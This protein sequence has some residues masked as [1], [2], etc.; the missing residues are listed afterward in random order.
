MVDLDLFETDDAV[1]EELH[2]DGRA[3]ICYFSAGSLEDWRDDVDD[4][5]AERVGAVLD[6]WEDERWV[7]IRSDAVREWVEAR[8]DHAVDRGC[9]GVEPDNVDAFA[10]PSGFDLTAADQLDFNRFVAEAAH[11]RG[12]SV[13]LKNDLDQ[14]EALVDHFDWALNEECV[15]YRE[16]DRLTP[17]TDAHKAVF[18]TEYV[19]RWDNAADKVDRVCGREG[20]STLVKTWDLGPEWMGCGTDG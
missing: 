15:A 4:L 7:D 3:V 19:N 10:N 1:L 13:G 8:L 17:F 2:R 20:L 5:P 16:C 6:G 18:H 12:L 11:A 14:I 9:D